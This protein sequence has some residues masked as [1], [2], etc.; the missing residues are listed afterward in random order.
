MEQ[1]LHGNL[2]RCERWSLHVPSP[3]PD[4][5]TKMAGFGVLFADMSGTS[6]VLLV[7]RFEPI[8]FAARLDFQ[9]N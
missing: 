6:P 5:L 2:A 1:L 8:S 7:H 3:P 4:L 9:N